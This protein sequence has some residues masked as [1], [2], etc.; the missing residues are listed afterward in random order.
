M[1]SNLAATLG[2]AAG[3]A[4]I[5]AGCRGKPSQQPE[6]PAPQVVQKGG[7]QCLSL[8]SDDTFKAESALAKEVQLPGVL[9]TTG[10][11]TF[12]DKKVT[13]ITSRVQG[14]IENVRVS[15][16]DTVDKGDSILELYSPDFMLAE[17]EYVQ[18][19]KS[20]KLGG[21]FEDVADMMFTAAKRK[22]M[23]LGMSESDIVAISSPSTNIWM[24]APMSGTILQNQAVIGANVNVGDTLYQ[25]GTLDRVWITADIYEV[26]LARVQVGQELEAVTETFPNEVF[27]GKISRISPTI[28]PSKQTAQIKC[29]V[30]NPGLKLK[31]QMLARVKIITK[32]G[33]ALVV[34][35]QALVYDGD[36]YYAFVETEPRLFQ[37]RAVQIGSWNKEGYT[38]VLS[39]LK[40][41]ERIMTQ[42]L[43]L[44]ALWHQ[45]RG[46]S[47]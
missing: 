20:Q 11:V 29:E 8:Q 18:A 39:G 7:Q 17:E 36:A 45:A 26:D 13:T 14:R 23:L 35:Q 34:P 25:L 5:A 22:L 37:R 28:D 27:K 31:P 12:D 19:T 38:R 1:K 47:Y 30:E 2:M 16:W 10:Q 24:R 33:T 44:N 6:A 32:P 21:G 9:E 41:G 15:V 4:I 42:S 40:A 46:E 43:E 3:L